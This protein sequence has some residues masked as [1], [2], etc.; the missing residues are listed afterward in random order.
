M[1]DSRYASGRRRIVT[2]PIDVEQVLGLVSDSRMGAVVPFLGVVREWTKGKRTLYLEYEA[3]GEMAEKKLAE[4]E[5]EIETRWPGSKAAI[6]HRVGRLNIGEIAV[7]VAV[8]SPHRADAFEGS[9]YGIERIKQV[10]PI[11]KKEYWEDGT[12]WIGHQA[13]PMRE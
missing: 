7:V 3:Y 1:E 12:A 13:G 6:V 11:W 5:S 8:A 9:R 10:V 2:G 4:I